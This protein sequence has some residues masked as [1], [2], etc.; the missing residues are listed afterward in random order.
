MSQNLSTYNFMCKICLEFA[1]NLLR[2]LLNDFRSSRSDVRGHEH[3]NDI[4]LQNHPTSSS[5]QMKKQRMEECNCNT[6]VCLSDTQHHLRHAMHANPQWVESN[7]ILRC[8]QQRYSLILCCLPAD[9]WGQFTIQPLSEIHQKKMIYHRH[10]PYRVSR[11]TRWNI[12]V[13]KIALLTVKKLAAIYLSRLCQL[14]RI[15]IQFTEF[16]T[17]QWEPNWI[18]VSLCSGL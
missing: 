10:F 12:S 11:N 3:Q 9:A 2:I 8:R 15:V 5:F 16:I 18:S 1:G 6:A 17:C 14:D 13:I 4:P 7:G